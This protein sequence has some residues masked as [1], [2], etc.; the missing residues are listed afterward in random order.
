MPALGVL[1]GLEHPYASV[2]SIMKIDKHWDQ[3]VAERNQWAE[4]IMEALP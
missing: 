2:D 4:G 1:K 3:R